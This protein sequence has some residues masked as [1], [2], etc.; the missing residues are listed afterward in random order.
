[1]NS[2]N[3]HYRLDTDATEALDMLDRWDAKMQGHLTQKRVFDRQRFRSK[4]IIRTYET[5]ND[6][7]TNTD[8]KTTSI[9]VWS[10]N[11][12]QEGISFIAAEVLELGIYLIGLNPDKPNELWIKLEI[13]RSRK[14]HNNFWEYGGKMLER[15]TK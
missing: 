10:R 2:S 11:I 8:N 15:M 14:V 9:M 1:M 5:T 12:S 6:E 3:Q 7:E 13:V 4:A